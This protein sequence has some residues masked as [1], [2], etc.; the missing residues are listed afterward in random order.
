M[1]TQT[2]RPKSITSPVDLKGKSSKTVTCWLVTNYMPAEKVGE[3][4]K[5]R[6]LGVLIEQ[7]HEQFIIQLLKIGFANRLGLYVRKN[8]DWAYEIELLTNMT[9]DNCFHPDSPFSSVFPWQ[10]NS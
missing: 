7:E 9:E 5:H 4:D 1:T 10:E 6:I 3:W 8:W 2:A